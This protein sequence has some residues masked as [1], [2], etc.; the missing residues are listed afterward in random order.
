MNLTTKLCSAGLVLSQTNVSIISVNSLASKGIQIWDDAVDCHIDCAD[1]TA[2]D[3]YVPGGIAL[4]DGGVHSVINKTMRASGIF[5][6]EVIIRTQSTLFPAQTILLRPFTH[7]LAPVYYSEVP[8]W[9]PG[10]LHLPSPSA[11]KRNVT[12]SSLRAYQNSNLGVNR[13]CGRRADKC[14]QGIQQNW[15]GVG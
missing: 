4:I 9:N 13:V 2:I 3:L 7:G 10:L 6:T 5:G 8:S 15:T 12:S 14:G 11:S 1:T